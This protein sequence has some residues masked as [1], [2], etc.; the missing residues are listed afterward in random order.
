[1]LIFREKALIQQNLVSIFEFRKMNPHLFGKF[2][3][4]LT[5]PVSVV[6]VSGAFA[7]D[8][9]S[10]HS[11]T[12]VNGQDV[13]ELQSLEQFSTPGGQKAGEYH[14][15][16]ILNGLKVGSESLMFIN[17]GENH[18]L[19]P[20]L[21]KSELENWGVDVKHI[22]SF[23]KLSD[24]QPIDDISHYIPDAYTRLQLTQQK[25][26]ISIPQIAMSKKASGTVDPSL[27]NDGIPALVLSY[28]YRGSNTW[29]KSSSADSSS[30]YVN[31]RSGL[32]IGPWRL[33]NYSTYSY[34]DNRSQWQ[35]IETYLER[36]INSIKSQLTIGDTSTPSDIFDGF[37]F[38]GI[39]LASDESMIPS[40]LRGF[41]PIIRGIAQSNAEVTIKQNDYII[42]QSYVSPGPFEI[43][44]LYSTGTSGDLTVT[45]KE[46]DGSE[47]SFVVPFSSLAIMQREGQ[48]KYSVTGGKFKQ[49]SSSKEP[50]FAQMTAIYGLPKGVTAYGGGLFSD[51][52][53]SY[54]A[55][56][57]LN[58]GYVGALSADVTQAKTKFSQFNHQRKT[59]QSYR[60][61]Y[62]KNMLSTGTTLT[63]AGYRYSTEGFYTFSEANSNNYNDRL[64]NKK[65][66]YQAMINQSLGDYGNIYASA[67]QQDFWNQRGQERTVNTGYSNSHKGYL[68]TFNY[69]YS[70]FAGN[71]KADHQ[72]VFSLSIPLS[73]SAFGDSMLNM[74]M[75]SNNHGDSNYMAGLSGSLLEDKNLN[76]SVQQSYGNRNQRAQGNASLSYKSG[77]GIANAGYSYDRFSQRANYGL[78]GAI[79]VHS[80]GVTLSQP[81][82]DS[83]AIVKAPGAEG[84]KIQNKTG[85]RTDSRGYAI[86]PYLNAY[87]QNEISLDTTSLPDNVDLQ[88]NSATLIPTKGA[89]MLAEFKTYT[90]Y[91]ILFNVSYHARA[92]PFGSVGQ[93]V[94]DHPE[95]SSSGIVGDNG[96]IYLSGMPEKG[97]IH[98][99]W[100]NHS[101]EQCTAHYQLNDKEKQMPVASLQIICE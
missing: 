22:A 33:K 50:N 66:R 42:Y 25:L 34:Q 49:N 37:Q 68:Y 14:V 69:S 18:K 27:W 44:D 10:P 2:I 36:G 83:F 15:D 86:V 80:D 67:Y 59:G 64:Y 9:F 23:D 40:S 100:G 95:I 51:D 35:N 98:I 12:P 55:G 76:Y 89:A 17:N 62:T 39:K 32:N 1:M 93:L 81:I 75:S 13:A 84:V 73:G 60:F 101:N 99:K 97:K 30:H 16:I 21:T 82:Y 87:A 38:R 54:A 72:F 6:F 48:F 85:I 3:A 45:V 41:A 4:S 61:Q 63:F 57:G 90:G 5:I 53:Q 96:D 47:R 71:N 79:V 88:K 77:Y 56:L 52:Y 8:Y 46:A 19:V 24:D 91:R 65:N 26:M 20:V 29:Y 70:D 11:L 28:F 92:I 74:S 43:N 78:N 7:D 58:L 94:S 31:L